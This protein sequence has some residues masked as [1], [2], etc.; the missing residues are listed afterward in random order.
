MNDNL[1]SKLKYIV[2]ATATI[3]VTIAPLDGSM[4]L[5]SENYSVQY[6]CQKYDWD[7]LPQNRFYRYKDAYLKDMD[8]LVIIKK[9]AKSMIENMEDLDPEISDMVSD[10]FWEMI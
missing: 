6:G 8:H 3:L 1:L 9:F 2:P 10:N 5:P 4:I 7:Q